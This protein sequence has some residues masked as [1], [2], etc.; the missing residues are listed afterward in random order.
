MFDLEKT[1]SVTPPAIADNKYSVCGDI[2]TFC[3]FEN[4]AIDSTTTPMAF[5]SASNELKIYSEDLALAGFRAITSYAQLTDY[6]SIKSVTKNWT[7]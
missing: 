7:I 5:Y 4:L 2:E 3:T 6:P 1:L